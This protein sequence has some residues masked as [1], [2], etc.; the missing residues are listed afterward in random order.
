MSDLFQESVAEGYIM[1]VAEVMLR[2]PWHTYQ[3]L[4]KRSTRLRSLLCGRLRDAAIAPHIWWGVSV[5]DRIHGL[6]RIEDLRDTPARTRFLSI[7][8]LL[9]HLGRPNLRGIHWV[10]V[11]GESGPGAR[12]MERQ[13]VDAIRQSG[14]DA[15]AGFF[16]KQW[17]GVQKGK[18]GRF[19]DGR[20]YDEMPVLSTSQ[21]PSRQERLDLRLAMAPLAEGW[22]N[23]PLVQLKPQ[24]AVA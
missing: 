19:L 3:V 24:Q 21:M 22:P 5:E 16:F 1:A 14:R 20:T 13:W 9:E 8:P 15:R 4:T 11:G 23:A 10:I 2:T 18:H 12:P 6:P 17:G 7:E